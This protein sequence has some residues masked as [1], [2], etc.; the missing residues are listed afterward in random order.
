MIITLQLIPSGFILEY[1][2]H[3]KIKLINLILLIWS[4]LKAV[5][6]KE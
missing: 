6:I 5:I 4:N 3:A 1:K 2:M